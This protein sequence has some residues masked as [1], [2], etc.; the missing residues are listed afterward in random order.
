MNEKRKNFSQLENSDKSK[1]PREKNTNSTSTP[2]SPGDV[3]SNMGAEHREIKELFL[4]PQRS[5]KKQI[6]GESNLSELT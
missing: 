1:T 4:L 2:T 6:K 5:K 3:F